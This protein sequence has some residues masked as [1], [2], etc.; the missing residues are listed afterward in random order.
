MS[1]QCG[2]SNIPKL[3]VPEFKPSIPQYMVDDI[4]DNTL[5][6]L[7]EQVSIIKQQNKWQSEHLAQV[8]DYTRKINGKV[9]ELE[10]F[11]QEQE[12][13]S[14]IKKEIEKKKL[15]RKKYIL[16]GVTIVAGIIYPL[17]ISIFLQAGPVNIAQSI[18]KFFQ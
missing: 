4:R 9:I 17:Y 3:E 5:K 1:E 18:A 15:S 2:P 10:K 8:F 6:F 14:T 16:P 13:D 7:I 11:R 12:I